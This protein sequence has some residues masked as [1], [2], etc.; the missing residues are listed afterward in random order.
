MPEKKIVGSE[1]TSPRTLST[2]RTPLTYYVAYILQQ[3]VE[4]GATTCPSLA[5]KRVTPHL[6]RHTSGMH[7]LQ[8]GVDITVIALWLAT[9]ALKRLT[10]MSKPI[11]L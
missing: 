10:V 3:A 1:T 8:A 5:K 9:R 2:R 7:L 4:R 11:W 6:I